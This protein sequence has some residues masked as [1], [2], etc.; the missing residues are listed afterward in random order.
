MAESSRRWVVYHVVGRDFVYVTKLFKTK[1]MAE[2]ER[3]KLDE[4]GR[5]WRNR[6]AVG[7]VV[8]PE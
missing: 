7:F 2:K 3:D 5:Y 1:Q 4:S 8:A 6:L